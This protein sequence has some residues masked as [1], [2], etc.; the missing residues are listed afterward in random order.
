M[1]RELGA[2]GMEEMKEEKEGAGPAGGQELFLLGMEI[3]YWLR[4]KSAGK[5]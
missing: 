3:V 5:R 1:E 4:M 2:E